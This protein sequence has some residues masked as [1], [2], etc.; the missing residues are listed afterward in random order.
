MVCKEAS[1]VSTT[2]ST[3]N[4]GGGGGGGG[5]GHRTRFTVVFRNQRRGNSGGGASS[6]PSLPGEVY[7]YVRT[8]ASSLRFP[9]PPSV[10]EQAVLH[11]ARVVES[12]ADSCERGANHVLLRGAPTDTEP[13]AVI[14][15]LP[16]SVVGLESAHQALD[17]IFITVPS[18]F[19]PSLG[20]HVNQSIEPTELLVNLS[21]QRPSSYGEPGRILVPLKTRKS[22]A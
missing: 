12:L 7:F 16:G 6:F 21:E 15:L 22:T 4:G 5:P 19:S 18:D 10:N 11:V 14:E 8:R 2:S 9:F 13:Q 3:A 20:V 17:A 1:H